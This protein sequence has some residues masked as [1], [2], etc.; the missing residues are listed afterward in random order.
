MKNMQ[1]IQKILTNPDFKAYVKAN[2]AAEKK[3][4]YCKH[5][6]AHFLD[7]ARIGYI[8][9]LETGFKIDK[10]ILYAAALLHDIGRFRQYED[11][12]PHEWASAQLCRPILRDAGFSEAEVNAIAEAILVHRDSATKKR[13]DLCGVLFNADKLSRNCTSCKMNEKC[14]WE[15]KNAEFTT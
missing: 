4:K 2:K 1:K 13:K 15:H 14:D 11:G 6:L 9:I 12:T 8:T 10:E 5:N 7:V 3:R